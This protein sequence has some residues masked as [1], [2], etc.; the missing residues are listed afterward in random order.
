MAL[1]ILLLTAEYVQPKHFPCL[2]TFQ[3]RWQMLWHST[4]YAVSHGIGAGVN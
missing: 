2:N 4:L 3:L 1:I